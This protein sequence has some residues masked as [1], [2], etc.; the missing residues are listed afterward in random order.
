MVNL[1]VLKE[2]TELSL[3]ISFCDLSN[4]AKL[5]QKMNEFEL[6]KFV[7]NFYGQIGEII[8]SSGGT[9]I[10]FIGDEALII[11]PEDKIDIGVISVLKLKHLIDGQNKGNG[12][13]SRLNVKIHFG[14]V[15]A[16]L[17]GTQSTKRLDIIGKEVNTAAL[18]KSN[19]FAMTPEVFRKLNKET[20]TLFKKH[21]P[22]ITYIPL[23][24]RHKD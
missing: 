1:S 24:E 21:T 22:P 19:G 9:I 12:I 13:D 20:R 10:K 23:E 5:S 3:L 15:V 6:F 14:K 11:Y 17:L 4:F 2:P 7:S 18:L 8:E 16:G